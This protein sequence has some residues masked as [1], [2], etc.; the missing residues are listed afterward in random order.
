MEQPTLY[1]SETYKYELSDENDI[2]KVV[3]FELVSTEKFIPLTEETTVDGL[4]RRMP[5]YSSD[6]KTVV[7]ARRWSKT[8]E[9]TGEQ[10]FAKIA[11]LKQEYLTQIEQPEARFSYERAVIGD[12]KN[13]SYFL[14]Y[15]KFISLNVLFILSERE[16][17]SYVEVY[18]TQLNGQEDYDF[19]FKRQEP[20]ALTKEEY[21]GHFERIWK[22]FETDSYGD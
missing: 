8:P 22:N 21:L 16:E 17:S 15:Y 13:P 2:S 12:P 5:C 1:F 10:F 3:K 9:I 20:T 19:Q 7:G 11:S 14:R 18:S 6:Y 4:D